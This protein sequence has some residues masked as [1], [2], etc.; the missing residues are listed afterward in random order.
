MMANSFQPVLAIG[1]IWRAITHCAHLSR[2]K[3][4][5]TPFQILVISAPISDNQHRSL[6]VYRP[7]LMLMVAPVVK[8]DRSFDR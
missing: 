1:D 6:L 7:P 2:I 4:P 8:P 3:S 5:E